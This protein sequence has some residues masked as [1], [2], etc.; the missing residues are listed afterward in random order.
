VTKKQ[1]IAFLQGAGDE[2]A[3]LLETFMAILHSLTHCWRSL[4]YS[5]QLTKSVGLQDVAMMAVSSA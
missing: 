3:V 4:R 2:K 5:R 1:E